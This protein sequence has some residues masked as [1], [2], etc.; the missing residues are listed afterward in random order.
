MSRR[1]L[2]LLGGM[3]AV[4][5]AA[6]PRPVRT[7]ESVSLAEM[8][9]EVLFL[10]STLTVRDEA[11]AWRR[12]N[13]AVGRMFAEE[14]PG[15]GALRLETMEGGFEFTHERTLKLAGGQVRVTNLVSEPTYSAAR[16]PGRRW[17]QG[18]AAAVSG[19][20]DAERAASLRAGAEVAMGRALNS[21]A[22]N[23]TMD[24]GQKEQSMREIEGRAAVLIAGDSSTPNLEVGDDVEVDGEETNLVRRREQEAVARGFDALELSFELA[25]AQALVQPGVLVFTEFLVP[26]E[27]KRFRRVFAEALPAMKAGE[28][29]KIRIKRD[30]YPVGFYELTVATS[31]FDRGLELAAD[32]AERRTAL[33]KA[34]AQQFAVLDHLSK[35]RDAQEAGEARLV[36]ELVD[37]TQ[38]QTW[39]KIG[40]PCYVAVDATGQV[41]ALFADAM[42]S[43]PIHD[44][45]LRTLVE[46]MV[47]VPS[48][49]AQGEGE[50][51]MVA[52]LGQSL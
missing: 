13:G 7:I 2:L 6:E 4:L 41:T 40:R 52:L 3:S 39:H 9:S 34:E 12:V 36:R 32:D 14:V 37:S 1:L 24:A 46:Q 17:L 49:S 20:M 10:G 38:R 42:R 33:T 16:D 26:G 30:G 25:P 19:T 31:F 5:G 35:H 48:V 28:R 43:E 27:V 45:A 47:F 23:Q 29:R 44:P 11:G 21:V 51:G 50:A 15:Q 18:Q 8:R 22:T